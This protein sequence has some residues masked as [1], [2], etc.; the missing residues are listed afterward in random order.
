[1]SRKFVTA[2]QAM[3]ALPDGDT[4]HTFF[5]PGG[6]LVGADWS[7]DDVQ[8]AMERAENIELAGETAK[9]LGHGIAVIPPN[10]KYLSDVLFVETD[11]AR[12]EALEE[13]TP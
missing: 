7:R 4:I 10:T 3:T 2:E 8:G 6:A 12:L 5:N 1:M 11:A 9:G 13:A